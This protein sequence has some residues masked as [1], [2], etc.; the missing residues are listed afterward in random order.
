MKPSGRTDDEYDCL[1]K[2][3]LIGDSGV[4]KTNLLTRFTRDEFT[5]RT[6]ETIGV[7]FASRS[8]QID[9]KTIKAQI[10]DTAGQERFRAVTPAYY[11]G[12]VGALVV[13]DI[14]KPESFEH[15]ERWMAELRDY[16]D[17]SIVVMLVG[18]KSD[19]RHLRAVTT[20]EAKDYAAKNK[21]FFIET[22]ARNATNVELAFQTVLCEIFRMVNKK[23][24][25]DTEKDNPQLVPVTPV[26]REEFR[27]NTDKPLCP[28]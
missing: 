11:R 10:W 26:T 5:Y 3:V 6:K 13:Y 7:E 1:L 15:V 23:P 20:D 4:G 12:A 19:L 21:L 18:N 28:C 27:S 9:G 2:I 22:S 8:I 24:S 16:A 17:P 14:T 25:E